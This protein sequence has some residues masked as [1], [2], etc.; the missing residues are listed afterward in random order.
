[1]AYSYH[2]KTA[3]VTGASSGIGEVFARE[4]AR[5]GMHL[6]LVARSENKLR[7]MAEELSRNHSIKVAV[8]PCDLIQ[9]GAAAKLLAECK[10]AG[11]TIDLLLNNAGFG[12]YGLFDTIDA[13]RDTELIQVNVT[14]LTEMCHAFLPEMV[15]RG[16]GA[17]INIASGAAFQPT[18]YMAAYGASKAY[19]LS[20]SEAL[21]A[22][23][24]KRGVH[25]LAV[26]PGATRTAFFDAAAGGDTM[27]GISMFNALMMTSDDVVQQSLRALERRKHYIING[28]INYLLAQSGR[29]TPRFLVA[30]V[31]Q[32]FMRSSTLK[33]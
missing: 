15:A 6:V 8:L 21:W 23:N 3:L 31:S 4:L 16:E 30:L 29:S 7:G 27:R 9:P 14:A 13:Q 26:C 11:L 24:R 10:T 17:I 25:V 18:P 1:M 33:T 12:T 2:G 28:W 22:E 19:V 32:F 20:L 5:R